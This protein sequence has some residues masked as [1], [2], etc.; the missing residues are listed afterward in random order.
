MYVETGHLIYA[1]AGT[2]WAVRFDLAKLEV[3][4]DAV[5]VV[6]HVMSLGEA[7]NFSV[8]ADG[9]LVYVPMGH[10]QSRSLVWVDRQGREEPIAAPARPYFIPVCRPMAHA[11][12]SVSGKERDSG[13]GISR[14][15]N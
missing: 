4:G 15:G 9:T 11:W 1:D 7:A 14:A 3:V 13:R 2:L 10:G 5:P 6:E 12:P 8:S